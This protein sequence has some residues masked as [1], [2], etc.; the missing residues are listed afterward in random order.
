M[1]GQVS[2]KARDSTPNLCVNPSTTSV[3]CHSHTLEYKPNDIIIMSYIGD[4]LLHHSYILRNR[5]VFSWPDAPP[6]RG[7]ERLAGR[8]GGASGH[9]T[10]SRPQLDFHH[11]AVS[12]RAL[13]LSLYAYA[14]PPRCSFMQGLEEFYVARI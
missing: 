6:T 12:A 1:S 14:A 4:V 11:N 3:I 9:V 5:L 10:A 8:P 7:K 13:A 2:V